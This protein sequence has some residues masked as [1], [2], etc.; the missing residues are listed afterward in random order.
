MPKAKQ[1]PRIHLTTVGGSAA[2]EV[3]RLGVTNIKGLITLAQSGVGEAYQVT[4]SAKMLL[5][6]EQDAKGGR[7][8]DAARARE[9]EN[10][11]AD[12]SVAAVVTM[13]GGA[14][15][16][17]ILDRINFDVLLK[18]RKMIYLLGFSEM[19]SLI[20]IAGQYPKAI[21][22]Y[23]LC[24][25]FI[26][27]GTKRFVLKNAR[28]FTRSIDLP[29]DQYEGFA[30]GFA[31]ANYPQAFTEF[32][33]GLANMLEGQGSWLAPTGRLLSGALPS[34]SKI[35]ITG[36]NLSVLL[37]LLGSRFAK[38][39]D[40]RSQWLAIEDVNESP[41]R[42]DRMLAGMKLNG[43]FEQVKGIILGDFHDGDEQLTEAVFKT[44]KYHL[45]PSR[46]IPIVALDN[47]GH[48]W[49]MAPLPMH[50]EVTLRS[51]R[52]SQGKPRITIDIPWSQWAQR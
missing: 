33:Q 40:T 32:F 24:P 7:T 20:A 3:A 36:G 25:G 35:T 8:D 22:L 52:T 27:G 21:G 43:L 2:E 47:F 44:L 51:L 1:K 4:A 42:I 9:I 26:Y 29:T 15:F 39:I 14:W 12:D 17:R 30:A 10:L 16:T 18:R 5:A 38:A 48:V 34:S 11:L 41:Q 37:P 31:L 45:P 13:R 46:R 50:R 28:K 19:T 23:Y 6:K 49:P